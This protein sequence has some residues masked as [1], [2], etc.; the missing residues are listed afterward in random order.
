MLCP[1]CAFEGEI[2]DGGCAHCGYGRSRIS[3][4][5]LCSIDRRI[6]IYNSIDAAVHDIEN[7][8]GWGFYAMSAL[9]I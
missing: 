6:A 4:G 5:P 2:I 9:W 7:G 8:K 3:S 1:C